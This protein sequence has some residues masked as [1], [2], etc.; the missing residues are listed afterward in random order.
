[1]K[2]TLPPSPFLPQSNTRQT[3]DGV[4]HANTINNESSK[5][6]GDTSIRPGYLLDAKNFNSNAFISGQSA[7]TTSVAAMTPKVPAGEMENGDLLTLGGKLPS[8][9]SN[10]QLDIVAKL[11]K[12]RER[13]NSDMF[14]YDDVY[15]H[16]RTVSISETT[17]DRDD[18][19]VDTALMDDDTPFATF[20]PSFSSASSANPGMAPMFPFSTMTS[21]SAAAL[22]PILAVINRTGSQKG[23]GP[24]HG[25]TVD[26]LNGGGVPLPVLARD[27]QRTVQDHQV[28]LQQYMSSRNITPTNR[29]SL[30]K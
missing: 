7:A 1:M 11:E 8:S 14:L 28:F 2:V 26:G 23:G 27:L 21:P 12:E 3:H 20:R 6:D 4:V 9:N 29:G 13:R 30:T 24:S 17:R 16:S 19:T 5:I 18:D 22:A 10:N 15:S 25:G